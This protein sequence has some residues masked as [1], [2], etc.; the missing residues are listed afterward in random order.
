MKDEF[1]YLPNGCHRTVLKVK[2]ANWHTKKAS[3]KKD[4]YIWY[5]FHSPAHA[6]EFP[7]GILR[8]VKGMNAKKDLLKR[9][10]ATR[11]I[12]AVQERML[13]ISNYNPITG[14][15]AEVPVE[16]PGNTSLDPDVK[17]TLALDIALESRV[18]SRTTKGDIRNKLPHIKKAAAKLKI[19]TLA[20]GQVSRKHIRALLGQL[21]K[22]RK[23]S[24]TNNQFNCYR[25][26]LSILFEELNELEVMEGNPIHGIKKRKV[27]TSPR[28]VL[29][30]QE[31]K[32]VDAHL[33]AN[34]YTFW[35]FVHVFF[36][37]GSRETEMVSIQ[38]SHVDLKRQRLKI[39]EQKGD[40]CRWIWK[41]IKDI[42]LPLW[43]EIIDEAQMLSPVESEK[44]FLFSDGLK[45]AIKA[46]AIS[47]LQI[48]RRWRSHVKNKLGITADFYSLK[49]LNTTEM[50]DI[51]SNQTNIQQAEKDVACLNGHSTTKMVA[52]VYDIKN[53]YRKED[54]VKKIGN[55]FA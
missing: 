16:I 5:R 30:P 33:K 54:V 14:K 19:D 27:A 24:W 39:L 17:F 18:M 46:R 51:L 37:S 3:L 44:V 49:H 9:Q 12:I 50:M 25:R 53:V 26:D 48:S 32:M 7:D 52:K 1:I 38:L 35:R 31:R 22:D 8:I 36:H 55:S 29:T 21:E 2:P 43:R 41:P 45:P 13:D 40:N 47:A 28:E 15:I 4:W 20:I 34:Y 10:E 6:L 23:A 42:V 11:Y